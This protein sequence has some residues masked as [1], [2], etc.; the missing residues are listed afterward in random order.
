MF[1]ERIWSCLSK[2]LVSQVI[3]MTMV[4][5]LTFIT[6][7]RDFAGAA[8]LS[9]SQL[10]IC[11]DT[12]PTPGH[13]QV[14]IF[15]QGVNLTKCSYLKSTGMKDPFETGIVLPEDGFVRLHLSQSEMQNITVTCMEDSKAQ[16]GTVQFQLD[17]SY[18]SSECIHADWLKQKGPNSLTICLEHLGQH[19]TKL[20]WN[21]STP[22]EKCLFINESAESNTSTSIHVLPH[23][24]SITLDESS[25]NSRFFVQCE[26]PPSEELYTSG[27]VTYS[28]DNMCSTKMMDIHQDTSDDSAPRKAP[29]HQAFVS[30]HVGL[31]ATF[32]VATL[33]VAGVFTLFVFRRIR[34]EHWR[35]GQRLLVNEE[36]DEAALREYQEMAT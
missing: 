5:T 11:A 31:F 16:S 14:A 22:L 25:R 23:N 21:A 29:I 10:Q 8:H 26:Y 33:V 27:P 9:D 17:T 32:V 3:A 24:V 7:E 12:K 19:L 6:L 15:W 34:R 18:S 36:P 20:S 1:Q 4:V 2:F 35:Q 13:G 28:S 30:K